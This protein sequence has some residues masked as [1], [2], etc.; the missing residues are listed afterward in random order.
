MRR[1]G[2]ALTSTMPPPC[3]SSGWSTLSHTTSTPQM[4]SPTI[5]AAATARVRHL[6]MHVV[7]H[8]GGRAAGAEV[9]VV[10][11]DDALPLGGTES[12]M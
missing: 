1:P 6:R 4:S 12:A 2:A 9:G 11:Q 8:I 5:C 10:A 7:G 3:S